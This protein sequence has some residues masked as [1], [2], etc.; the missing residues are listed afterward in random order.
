MTFGA[1]ELPLARLFRQVLGMPRISVLVLTLPLVLACQDSLNPERAVSL[2]LLSGGGSDTID[3]F[4]TLTVEARLYGLPVSGVEVQFHAISINADSEYGP[5]VYFPG[6]RCCFTIDDTTDA[7]GRASVL[8]I[9]GP[10]AGEAFV[11]ITTERSGKGDTA[12]FTTN[13]G[14]PVA[15]Q[16][17]PRDRPIVVGHDY[18]IGAR[19][20]DRR[21]NT[22]LT[23]V[24]FAPASNIVAVDPAGI[25]HGNTIGRAKINIQIGTWIDSA[26]TS[27]VPPATLAFLDHS[28]YV[29]DS[30]GYSQMSLDGSDYRRLFNTFVQGSSYS[31]GNASAPQ[32]IPGTGQ[33]IHIRVVAGA[34]RLFVGD[35]T[36]GARR[37]IDTPGSIT[38]EDDPDVSPDGLWVYFVG[39]SA[40]G[41]ALWRVATSGGAPER[42]TPDSSYA[43]LY[44][45]SISP[46]GTRIVYV[47]WDRAYVRDLATGDT[48]QLATTQ[49]AGTRWSPA[50]DWILY[51]VGLPYA[52]YSGTLHLIRPDGTADH[53]LSPAD[54][55]PGGS[56]SP[57]AR[58]VIVTGAGPGGHPELIEI[59][60]GFRLPLVYDRVWY[61]P[62]W[63]R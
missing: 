50:G 39:H 13:H 55:F 31:P 41:D 4:D 28:G 25:I 42:L 19:L 47:K 53:V 43:P 46:D 35:S 45:P 40:T 21:G 8:A 38:A 56:W 22:I 48:T 57:D 15:T 16:V 60:T 63:R 26:F 62:A 9:H 34:P 37:L 7:R 49:A 32:W 1:L 52:G 36:G 54:Y 29:G 61:G 3:V 10:G 59:A 20:M 17:E 44:T 11:V 23:G 18:L 12:F 58:Y 5:A 51:A 33:L 14:A 30:S 24:T 6:S 27:V 2:R